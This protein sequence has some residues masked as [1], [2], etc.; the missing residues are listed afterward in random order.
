MGRELARCVREGQPLL[1]IDV[2][3]FKAVND[4]Y[5]HQAGDE[6]LKQLAAILVQEVR[7]SDLACRYGGEEFLV[8]FPNMPLK[9]AVERAEQY[10]HQV[11]TSV[12]GFGGIEI[13]THLS[14]GVA[15]YPG[16]AKTAEELI[17]VADRALYEAKRLGR[18]RVTVG[19]TTA[20]AT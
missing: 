8:L 16:H 10:R 15:C 3:H 2:D 4:T 7:G 11:E 9:T 5:G 13:S 19:I 14:I 12:F 6:V 1:M 17:Q 18:N 20:V